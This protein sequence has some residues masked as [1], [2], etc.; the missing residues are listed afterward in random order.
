MRLANV[1]NVASE[2]MML[3]IEATVPANDNTLPSASPAFCSALLEIPVALC[4]WFRAL[5]A[6]SLAASAA[7]L[8]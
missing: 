4:A 3:S 5:P 7:L 2:V 1:N 6:A 8:F